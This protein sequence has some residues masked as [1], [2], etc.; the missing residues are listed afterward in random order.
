MSE[1]CGQK[2]YLKID[3]YVDTRA[4]MTVVDPLIG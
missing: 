3:A 1:I 2:Q 4:A